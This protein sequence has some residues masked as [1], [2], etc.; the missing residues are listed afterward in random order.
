MSLILCHYHS[1]SRTF[2]LTCHFSSKPSSTKIPLLYKPEQDDQTDTVTPQLLSWGKGAS[3]QLSGGIE[4]I[5][6]YPTPVANLI[7]SQSS[8]SLSPTPGRHVSPTNPFGEVGLSYGLFHSSLPVNGKLWIW[9]KG[10]GG[11]LG[12]GHENPLFV[13]T[14]NPYLGLCSCVLSLIFL[15]SCVWFSGFV[16]EISGFV[17]FGFWKFWV[18]NLGFFSHLTLDFLKI[19]FLTNLWYFWVLANR[20]CFKWYCVWLPTKQ[21]LGLCNCLFLLK[22][23]LDLNLYYFLFL[24]QFFPFFHLVKIHKLKF[25]F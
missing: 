18:L 12:F 14:L 16:L 8:F 25:C 21:W 7:V 4:E 17:F 10:D 2:I 15:C 19:F 22:I 1:R 5:C 11:R 24:F 20:V 13:P 3:D 23:K 9:G 6:L